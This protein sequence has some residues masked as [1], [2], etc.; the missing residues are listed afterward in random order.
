MTTDEP[1][2]QA[3]MPVDDASAA[4]DMTTRAPTVSSLLERDHRL[5]DEGV[6][7]FVD[8]ARFGEL[9][10]DLLAPAATGLRL[11]IYLEEEFLFP[12]LRTAGLIPPVLVMLRE[13]GEIWGGLDQLDRAL[14][15]GVEPDRV[16]QI[17]NQ[18]EDV[19]AQHNAKEERILYPAADQVIT[20]DV[21]EQIRTGLD[22]TLPQGWVCEQA[23]RK[24]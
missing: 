16:L 20:D 1:S 5:I 18:V 9:R 10:T 12:P 6:A 3:T 21:V 23:R 14:E 19:L 24:A 2:E 7:A 11:H 15:A 8:A 17:C 22:D 4:E 13:H